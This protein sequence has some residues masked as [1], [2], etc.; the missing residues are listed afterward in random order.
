MVVVDKL[1]KASHFIPVKTTHKETN[2]TKTYMKE[3][4]RIH[5]VPKEIVSY[6]DCKLIS[7]FW[8][9]LFKGFGT[10]LSFGTSYYLE[11]DG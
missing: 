10:N 8:K 4:A 2:I 6:R 11:S 1:T 9:E 7:N 5:G 3:I